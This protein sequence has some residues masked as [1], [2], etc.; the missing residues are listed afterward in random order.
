MKVKILTIL[1]ILALTATIVVNALANSLPLNGKTTGEISDQYANLFVPTPLTFSIWAVI[2]TL[3]VI[4]IIV[5]CIRHR[6]YNLLIKAIGPWFALSCVANI[7]WI[8]VWHYE[9]M[10]WSLLCML[11]LF[12]TLTVIYLQSRGTSPAVFRM[13]ISVY[14]GWISVALIANI[15]AVL[16]YLEWNRWGVSEL[17]WTVTVIVV[18]TAL[19]LVMLWQHRDRLF[20][21]VVAWALFGIV[22]KES[23]PQ[24][25]QTVLWVGL[26]VLAVASI[27]SFLYHLKKRGYSN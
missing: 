17:F 2:Y 20:L 4:A 23:I 13:A 18:A 7:A 10:P 11:A 12:G 3:L 9:W 14:Y 25:M 1:N 6:A 26:G 16:V 19:A 8:T 27:L 5:L 24:L 21:L 15:A 22:R